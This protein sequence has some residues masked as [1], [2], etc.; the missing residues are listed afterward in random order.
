M[1]ISNGGRSEKDSDNSHCG[2]GGVCNIR[3]FLISHSKVVDGIGIS[4]VRALIAFQLG[5]E[6]V[7]ETCSRNSFD[8][9]R[10]SLFDEDGLNMIGPNLSSM[11]NQ[12]SRMSARLS[13]LV[14]EKAFI[15]ISMLAYVTELFGGN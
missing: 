14:T 9:R 8:F 7:L 10:M 5:V 6:V 4:W 1:S 12:T 3:I 2:L 11:A 15:M 13:P